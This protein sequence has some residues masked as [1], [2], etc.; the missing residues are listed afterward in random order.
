M[1]PHTHAY[2]QQAKHML[3]YAGNLPTTN[4]PQSAPFPPALDPHY[5]EYIQHMSQQQ[6]FPGAPLS[7]LTHIERA[8]KTGKESTSQSSSKV[9]VK[10]LSITEHTIGIL[11]ILI[12]LCKIRLANMLSA[13]LV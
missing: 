2:V 8:S 3:P 7:T 11:F 6:V 9:R 4:F 5:A 13:W 10:R 12:I 1:E